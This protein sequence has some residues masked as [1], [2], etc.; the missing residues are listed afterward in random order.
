[1]N[2]TPQ[3]LTDFAE[4]LDNDITKLSNDMQDILRT[5]RASY[6]EQLNEYHQ[7]EYSTLWNLRKQLFTFDQKI[8]AVINDYERFKLI[9]L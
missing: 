2:T 5:N 9:N 6:P 1:M 7:K 4:N 3:Q 8:D